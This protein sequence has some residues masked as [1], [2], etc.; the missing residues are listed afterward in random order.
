M[1]D[2]LLVNHG[3]EK[4]NP[5]IEEVDTNEVTGETEDKSAIESRDEERTDGA[6]KTKKG[7]SSLVVALPDKS[8]RI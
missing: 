7:G 2:Q 1:N 5:D 4:V 8:G 3:I 6:K